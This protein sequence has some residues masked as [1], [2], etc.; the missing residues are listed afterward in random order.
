MFG[1]LDS[2]VEWDLNKTKTV[3]NL[4]YS[5]IVMFSHFNNKI[6]VSWSVDSVLNVTV[7]DI[8]SSSKMQHCEM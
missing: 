8:L 6:R 7:I 2:I 3:Q 1:Y 5:R 4:K